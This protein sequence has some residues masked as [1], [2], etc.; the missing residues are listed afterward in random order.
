MRARGGF[1]RIM[2]ND[3]PDHPANPPRALLRESIRLPHHVDDGAGRAVSGTSA[4]TLLGAGM[5]L[6]SLQLRAVW[7]VARGFFV[8]Q[9]A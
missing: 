9:L 7:A 3:W 5:L 2:Y 4:T 6:L 1:D 8:S